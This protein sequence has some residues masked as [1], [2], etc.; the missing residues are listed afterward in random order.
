MTKPVHSSGQFTMGTTDPLTVY[1]LG[2]GAMRITGPGIWGD[3]PITTS[4]SG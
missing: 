4:P 3:P 2:F 1:R